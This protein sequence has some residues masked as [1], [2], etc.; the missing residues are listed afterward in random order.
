MKYDQLHPEKV[1]QRVLSSLNNRGINSELVN[2][3]EE[4]LNR[5][6][7]LIPLKAEIMTAGSTTLEEIG[8][9][10]LLK[11]SKHKW[12]N[13]K[14]EL[15]SEKNEL[16]QEELR[17]KSVTAEFFIGSVHAVTEKGE[18]LVAS[19]SGSQIPAY[20]FS[21]DNLIWI[22][23]VQKI[24]SNLNE[25]FKRIREYVFPLEDKRMKKAG[26]PGSVIGKILLFEREIMSNRKI[27]LIF[28][29]EK[30]GF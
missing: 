17:K 28:V 8:F 29:N 4:A 1:V 2:T 30:L 5:L 22:V 27:T 23:G 20:S 12:K 10:N 24:V 19:A 18:V 25:G 6:I 9:I 7:E 21:S 15:L 3:K 14:D 26:Y 13:L 16:K 11:S